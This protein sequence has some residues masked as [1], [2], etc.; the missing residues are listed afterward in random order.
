MSIKILLSPPIVF[1]VG[2][3]LGALIYVLG[4]AMAPR[5]GPTPGKF[6]PY[7]CGED[8]PM[9]KAQISYRLFF[10]LAVFFTVMHV[11]ALV[12]TTVPGGSVALLGVCYL[13]VIV[14]SVFA[15]VTSS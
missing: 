2:L 4:R 12:V 3:A 5:P 7:A 11:A 8:V 10:S 15:L 13:A 6:A 14:F 9:Q 1:L